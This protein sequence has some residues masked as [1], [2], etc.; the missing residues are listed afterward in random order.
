MVEKWSNDVLTV[1]DE[2][3][4]TTEVTAET[5]YITID[6]TAQEQEQEQEQEQQGSGTETKEVNSGSGLIDS[7]DDEGTESVGQDDAGIDRSSVSS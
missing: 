1:V 6:T 7:A 5:V 2:Q 4:L 3:Q